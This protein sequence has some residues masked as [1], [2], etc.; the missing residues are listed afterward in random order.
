MPKTTDYARIRWEV[1]VETIT[2]RLRDMGIDTPRRAGLLRK[3]AHRRAQET[4]SL[5]NRLQQTHREIEKKIAVLDILCG[6]KL[7]APTHA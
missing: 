3:D 5:I 4:M 7:E 2:E 1:E 6:D